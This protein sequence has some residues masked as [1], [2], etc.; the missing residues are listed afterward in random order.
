LT[1]GNSDKALVEAIIVMAHKLGIKT[2][3]E[4]VETAAQRDQL[5]AFGCDFVQGYLYSRPVPAGEFAKMLEV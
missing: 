4:G 5:I 2:V 1:A 3:A